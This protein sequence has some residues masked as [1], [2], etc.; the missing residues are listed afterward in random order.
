[1][2]IILNVALLLLPLYAS[3]IPIDDKEKFF[4]TLSTWH[5]RRQVVLDTLMTQICSARTS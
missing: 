5:L 2:T 3:D 1:M 4:K